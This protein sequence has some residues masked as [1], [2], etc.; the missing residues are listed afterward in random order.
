MQ[1]SS[2]RSQKNLRFYLQAGN[3]AKK[4]LLTVAIA[5]IILLVW[6]VFFYGRNSFDQRVFDLVRP[7]ITADRT[8]TMGLISFLGKH[9]FLLPVI[10]LMIGYFIFKKNRWMV[11]RS[12]AVLLSSLLLMTVLKRLMHRNRPPDPL[13]DG[14]TNFSFPSGHAVMSVAFYGLLIWYASVT[15]KTRWVRWLLILLLLFII[16]AIGFSRIYLR[17]HYAT[18]VVAGICIGFVWLDFCLWFIDK[19]QTAALKANPDRSGR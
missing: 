4:V 17:V 18:D 6:V 19:K 8:R 3:L 1:K 14:I 16:A 11:I 15:I 7:H 10:F 2:Q 12:S 13:V 5:L 9:S